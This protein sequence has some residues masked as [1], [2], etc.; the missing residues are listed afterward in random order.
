VAAGKADPSRAYLPRCW[1]E[2]R[3]AED[4]EALWRFSLEE[5]G[6]AR[7]RLGLTTLEAFLALVS[8]KPSPGARTEAGGIVTPSRRYA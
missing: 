3:S 1:R 4:G 8:A 5:V 6:G 7:R 2:G